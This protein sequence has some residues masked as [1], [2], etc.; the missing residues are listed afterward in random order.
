MAGSKPLFQQNL[1]LYRVS[2]EKNNSWDSYDSFIV[3]ARTSSDAKF[4]HPAG[5]QVVWDEEREE[6]CWEDDGTA[7]PND[8]WVRP[9]HLLG[10]DQI[11]CIGRASH[12]VEVGDV[13]CSSF[14]AG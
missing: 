4:F 13:I 1:F 2:Q 9:W 10:E 8:D 12:G 11:V 7:W 5:E 3:A 14:N 6:W